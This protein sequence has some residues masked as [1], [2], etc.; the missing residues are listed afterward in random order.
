MYEPSTAFTIC[1]SKRRHKCYAAAF[2]FSPATLHCP[3]FS[4]F[5]SSIYGALEVRFHLIQGHMGI[6]TR[7]VFFVLLFPI[8]NQILNIIAIS[9]FLIHPRRPIAITI[10]LQFYHIFHSCYTINSHGSSAAPKN[11][12]GCT[13][14]DRIPCFSTRSS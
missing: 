2:L 4:C 1:A 9:L 3:D 13:H 10:L 6:L 14:R 12:K 8:K 5:K 7:G 11:K